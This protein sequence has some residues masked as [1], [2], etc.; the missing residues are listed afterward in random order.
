MAGEAGAAPLGVFD[1][2]PLYGRRL[3]LGLG[4]R[5]L[6]HK[7]EPSDP[8][9]LTEVDL[10]DAPLRPPDRAESETAWVSTTN[11]Q[12]KIV[13]VRRKDLLLSPP[14]ASYGWAEA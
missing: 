11:T 13:W 2:E 9:I 12:P 10:R 3:L 5:R 1:P 4:T 14:N 7:V 6:R 8:P